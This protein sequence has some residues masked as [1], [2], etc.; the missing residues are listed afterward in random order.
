[1]EILILHFRHAANLNVKGV[2]IVGASIS[3]KLENNRSFGS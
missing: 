1:M 3:G 2:M